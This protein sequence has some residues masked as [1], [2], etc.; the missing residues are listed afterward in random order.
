[1]KIIG[2]H[3][4][5][6][7]LHLLSCIASVNHLPSDTCSFVSVSHIHTHQLTRK[8]SAGCVAA[9]SADI[10][11]TYVKQDIWVQTDG[12]L[13]KH[14]ALVSDVL[15]TPCVH[16]PGSIRRPNGGRPS[17]G[18]LGPWFG[19]QQHPSWVAS[20]RFDLAGWIPCQDAELQHQWEQNKS[21]LQHPMY[22]QHRTKQRRMVGPSPVTKVFR[23]S[24]SA[25]PQPRPHLGSPGQECILVLLAQRLQ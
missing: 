10:I 21:E 24:L 19:D 4:P 1:M 13:L 18:P 15:W 16:L 2:N 3:L 14:G 23:W 8:T 17:V 5:S 9:Q 22:P 20:G 25:W 7:L 12:R 11:Y 6:I